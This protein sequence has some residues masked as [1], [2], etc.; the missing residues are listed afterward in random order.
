MKI[1]VICPYCGKKNSFDGE[2]VELHVEIESR[3]TRRGSVEKPK[4]RLVGDVLI[5]AVPG[6]NIEEDFGEIED[7]RATIMCMHCGA[8]IDLYDSL[9]DFVIDGKRRSD[10]HF[11]IEIRE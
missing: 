11:D 6:E 4:L 1:E 10:I 9:T 8:E 2:D 5:A 7:I 3:I